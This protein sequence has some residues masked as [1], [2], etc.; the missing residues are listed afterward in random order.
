[1]A[2]SSLTIRPKQQEQEDK[3]RS[4]FI[5]SLGP[6]TTKI[7]YEGAVKRFMKFHNIKDYSS[8][9]KLGTTITT[10]NNGQIQT[11]TADIEDKIKSYIVERVKN[12]IST[13]DMTG[14]LASIK[15]F[16][17][18]NDIENIRWRKLRRYM[19]EVTPKN[20]D[21]C[22]THEEIHT[23]LDN[24]DLKLKVIILLMASAGLRVGAL[25]TLLYNHLEKKDSVY[26]INVYKGLK[27]KGKYYTFCSP[28]CVTAIDTYLQYRE[29]CGENIKG[30]SSLLRKDF[31]SSLKASKVVPATYDGIRMSVYTLLVKTGIRIIGSNRRNRKDISMTHGFRKFYETMLVISNIHET[32]IRKLTGHSENG[33]LTQR[34]ARQTEE[35]ML[36]EYMKAVDNLTINEE[37]R[38]KHKVTELTEK[39][40]EIALMRLKHETEMK[41]M[42]QD[43]NKII[44]LIQE[45]PKL[46]RVKKE[47]LSEI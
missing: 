39:Q 26:K 19:G 21:R 5:N 46:A 28:E 9:L 47:V 38:L 23:L 1:M 20:E 10:V 36:D 14:F 42:R 27:G 6:E 18:S 2:T 41:E 25:P 33:N 12:N 11:Q 4:N 3:I 44:S 8:L 35:K 22:Y 13:S 30:D 34:Y 32:I 40:D 7:T 45:N 24:S 31:D 43:M 15:N 37:N 16:Y 29:R 17:E